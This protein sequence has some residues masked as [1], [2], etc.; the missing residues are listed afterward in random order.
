MGHVD[1]V[2]TDHV[3]TAFTLV[4]A[5]W[6]VTEGGRFITPRCVLVYM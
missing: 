5:V 4:P 2:D 6:S 1:A 3:S